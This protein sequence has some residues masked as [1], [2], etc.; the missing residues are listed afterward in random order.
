MAMHVSLQLL[1]Y[2]CTQILALL[3][4]DTGIYT[5]SASDGDHAAIFVPIVL[6]EFK[7]PLRNWSYGYIS[8]Y[9]YS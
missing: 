5:P 1:D 4:K 9:M 8:H 3:I 2:F 6:L 7:L